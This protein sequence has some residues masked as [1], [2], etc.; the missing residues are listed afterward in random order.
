MPG[1]SPQ[2]AVA[3]P[4]AWSRHAQHSFATPTCRPTH[5]SNRSNNSST[6]LASALCSLS[7]SSVQRRHHLIQIY[8][9]RRPRLEAEARLET[10]APRRMS[11][12]V[13]GSRRRIR[14]RRKRCYLI[15]DD[16]VWAT[17][18]AAGRAPRAKG[19]ARA[20]GAEQRWRQV[21]AELIRVALEKDGQDLVQNCL[22]VNAAELR[23]RGHRL[24]QGAKP[25]CRRN[26]SGIATTSSLIPPRPAA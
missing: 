6:S 26:G 16:Y 25:M 4:L 8:F 13:Q 5:G 9:M 1:F 20:H 22:D 15:V 7:S 2:A 24:Q 3:H 11:G 18:W 21:D 19:L 12:A 10:L 23:T 14:R 17:R